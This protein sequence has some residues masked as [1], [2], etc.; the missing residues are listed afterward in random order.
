MKTPTKY[1]GT[2]IIRTAATT[3]P[4]FRA[5]SKAQAAWDMICGAGEYLLAERYFDN[6]DRAAYLH[7]LIAS[8][9]VTVT[10]SDGTVVA[11]GATVSVPDE[12]PIDDS[13]VTP[14]DGDDN[15]IASLI[16]IGQHV[17][18]TGPAGCGKTFAAEAAAK[19]LGRDF[20]MISCS[21]G[22][23][24][25]QLLGWLLPVGA[26]GQFE[27]VPSA[28]VKAY[29]NGG[30]FLFDELDAADENVLLVV[31]SALAND[32]LNVPSRY[33]QPWVKRHPDFV[34]IGTANTLGNGAT[35]MY[36]GRNQL[37]ASTMDRFRMGIVEMSYD[38]ALE[39]RLG[40]RRVVEWCHRVR[41][42]INQNSLPYVMSTRVII[43]MSRRVR[44]AKHTPAACKASYLAD[45]SEDHKVILRRS[46]TA[47]GPESTS[48]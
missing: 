44:V 8:G 4:Q 3:Q 19:T 17:L 24:E 33:T 14:H 21:A 13:P 30:V 48:A 41:R 46:A 12:Q 34:C 5:N 9:H 2:R 23:S 32:R 27:Y 20:A 39:Q 6:V 26:G 47:A 10:R 22:M 11:T 37:D 36:T 28:F 29:E 40:V 18:L 35:E 42:V 1:V 7:H 45:W 16:S 15:M 43:D 38:E 31:N 25:A